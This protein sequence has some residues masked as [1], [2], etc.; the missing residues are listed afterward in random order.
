MPGPGKGMRGEPGKAK[1]ASRKGSGAY[2]AQDSPLEGHLEPAAANR[3]AAVSPQPIGR[4][5]DARHGYKCA[6]PG[7]SK[8]GAQRRRDA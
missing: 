8:S 2:S 7:D 1:G 3:G 5:R 6:R 4:R